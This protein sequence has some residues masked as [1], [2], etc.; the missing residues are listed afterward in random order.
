V[1]RRNRLLCLQAH[2]KTSVGAALNRCLDFTVS[3]PKT[4]SQR[5]ARVGRSSSLQARPLRRNLRHEIVLPN[6]KGLKAIRCQMS[7]DSETCVGLCMFRCRTPEI[8]LLDAALFEDVGL[9]CALVNLT[10]RVY[11]IARASSPKPKR[12]R[13]IGGGGIGSDAAE[14]RLQ[15]PPLAPFVVPAVASSSVRPSCH[16]RSSLKRLRSASIIIAISSSSVI[17]GSQ[18]SSFFTFAVFPQRAGTSAGRDISGSTLTYSRQSSP[19]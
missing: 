10:D 19:T 12:H 8:V 5:P 16:Q 2:I 15:M 11:R 13:M 9:H 17:V 7:T 3:G 14:R 6:F 4:H 1:G 18:P